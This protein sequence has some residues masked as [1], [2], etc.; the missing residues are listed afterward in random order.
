MAGRGTDILLGAGV[1]ELGGLHII[2]TERHESR[3]IDNQL[4]GRAGR[5]GD[6]G[7]SRFYLSLDDD[8]MRIFGSDWIRGLAD[9]L[10]AEEGEPLFEHKVLSRAVEN[11]QRKV[12]SMHFEA[13]KHVLKYDDVME[14]QRSI[15]YELRG[16]ILRGG[17][18]KSDIL[19]M[20]DN[21][22]A[23]ILDLYAPQKSSAGDWDIEALQQS[24]RDVFGVNMEIDPDHYRH[25]DDILLDA[26]QAVRE[27]YFE[28][29]K[30]FE[31]NIFQEAQRII[32]LR[33]L[34][35]KWLGTS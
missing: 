20:C 11:A 31:Q 25:S 1:E 3:R 6:P 4:R 21:Q 24:L 19:S 7:S 10:G 12:E 2:G 15:I 34:D 22:T 35:T 23:E 32:L 16:D 9:K 8:L 29:E 18:P 28:R 13:R 17:N 14:K 30:L 33:A 26:Q 27:R 5:Q